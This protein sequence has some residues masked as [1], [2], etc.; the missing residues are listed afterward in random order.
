MQAVAS[1][2]SGD[3]TIHAWFDR[4]LVELTRRCHIHF[5]FLPS[6]EREEAV[7][8][9]VAAAV[10]YVIRAASR[11]KLQRLTLGA[12]VW[13]FGRSC[14]EGRQMAGFKATDA[15]SEAAR[16]RH[17]HQVLSFNQPCLVH[18][19]RGA[20]IARLSEVLADQRENSPY[21][22]VRR[23]LDYADILDKERVNL[24]GRRVFRF[25]AECHG[26][27]D[28]RALAR[29]LGVTPGRVSQLK[30]QL[31]KCLGRHG[32]EPPATRPARALPPAQVVAVA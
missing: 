18:T 22:N 11:G 4:H 5:R 32:Y 7:A 1:V 26:Q 24:K 23:D 17:H 3:S 8:E 28:H 20:R 13:F 2:G 30:S 10:Q 14:R 25:L 12:L 16:R 29:E 27:G 31:A 21:D 6:I 15:M 9:T 19:D